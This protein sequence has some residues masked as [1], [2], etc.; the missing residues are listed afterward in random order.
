MILVNKQMNM[1]EINPNTMFLFL[2]V[3]NILKIQGNL[4]LVWCLTVIQWFVEFYITSCSRD[5]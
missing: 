5:I 2:I 1:K 3:D 4:I